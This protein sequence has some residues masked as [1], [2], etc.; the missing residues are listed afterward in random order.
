MKENTIKAKEYFEKELKKLK[1]EIG[2]SYPCDY[3]I[4]IL[5]SSDKEK[6]NEFK[7]K[8]FYGNYELSPVLIC[9]LGNQSI[10]FANPEFILDSLDRE[11]IRNELKD[12]KSQDVFNSSLLKDFKK[13][14]IK[15]V[16]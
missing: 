8:F 16:K 12:I 3:E 13:E 1:I 10:Y 14:L 15:G 2:I 9:E 7:F 4:P 5:F 11:V 6:V